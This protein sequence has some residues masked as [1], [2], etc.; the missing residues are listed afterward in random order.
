VD[1]V[2]AELD[3]LISKRASHDRRPDP[4]EQEELWKAGV[5]AHNE[6]IYEENRLAWREYHQGQAERL[7][8]LVEPLIAF[9]EA[10][11]ASLLED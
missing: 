8:H 2:D 6:R 11:A 1:T 3:W 10:R 9:H 4:D 7:R 5:R